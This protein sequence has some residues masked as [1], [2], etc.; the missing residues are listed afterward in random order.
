M[1][2]H[3]RP[4]MI[5]DLPC[6]HTCV[7]DSHLDVLMFYG[8]LNCWQQMLLHLLSHSFP[9]LLMEWEIK[10]AFLTSLGL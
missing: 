1:K 7:Y 5:L 3:L 6:E 4:K 9:L 10:Y 8:V 2:L